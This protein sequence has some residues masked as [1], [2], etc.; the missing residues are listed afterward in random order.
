MGDAFSLSA[1]ALVVLV[2]IGAVWAIRNR[3]IGYGARSVRCPHQDMRATISVVSQ[4]KTGRGVKVERDSLQCS[5][6]AGRARHVPQE[7]PG[8]VAIVPWR[9][10]LNLSKRSLTQD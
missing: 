2:Y 6:P 9:E 5:A 10:Q 4:I 8:P 7:L 3:G 1:V